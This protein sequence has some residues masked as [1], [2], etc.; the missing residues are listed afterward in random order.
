MQEG[1]SSL[2]EDEVLDDDID[3]ENGDDVPGAWK[4]RGGLL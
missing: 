2:E 3:H 4:R 1:G